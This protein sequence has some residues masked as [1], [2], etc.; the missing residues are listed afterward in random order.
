MMLGEAV[1]VRGLNPALELN[2]GVVQ[3]MRGTNLRGNESMLTMSL[4]GPESV[5]VV[6]H[7]V[8]RGKVFGF[9]I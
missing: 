7:Y 8:W 1:S 4:S 9:V 5:N 6:R 3:G 2:R